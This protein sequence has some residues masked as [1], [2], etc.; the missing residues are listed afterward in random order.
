[1]CVCVTQCLPLYTHNSDN[2]RMVKLNNYLLVH[3][4][5]NPVPSSY[6][7]CSAVVVIIMSD[8]DSVIILMAYPVWFDDC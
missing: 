8:N 1:M 5:L 4:H 2:Q 3:F 6:T 7:Q